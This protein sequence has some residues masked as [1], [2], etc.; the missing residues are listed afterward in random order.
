MT[1]QR[2]IAFVA[3]ASQLGPGAPGQRDELLGRRLGNGCTFDRGQLRGALVGLRNEVEGA[4]AYA[5]WLL[6]DHRKTPRDRR[7][8]G[9]ILKVL[10]RGRGSGRAATMIRCALGVRRFASLRFRGVTLAKALQ[11]RPFLVLGSQPFLELILK[12]VVA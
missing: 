7:L 12:I 2:S 8:G 5:V 9:T 10:C 11:W 1:D 3:Q 6:R 4:E